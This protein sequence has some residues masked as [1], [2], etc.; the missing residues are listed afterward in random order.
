M[1]CSACKA[2]KLMMALCKLHVKAVLPEFHMKAHKQL[3]LGTMFLC[4]TATVY[5]SV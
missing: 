5:E 2:N 3:I 1:V 4:I